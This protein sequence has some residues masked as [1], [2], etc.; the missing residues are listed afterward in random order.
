MY[1]SLAALIAQLPKLNIFDDIYINFF[2]ILHIKS[3]AHQSRVLSDRL[4]CQH[5][6]LC[7]QS[8]KVELNVY[9]QRN[10]EYLLN[11]L[12]VIIS[13]F[14][15]IHRIQEYFLFQQ[16]CVFVSKQGRNRQTQT[17]SW[18]LI[19]FFLSYKLRMYTIF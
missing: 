18:L 10:V 15:P 5:C 14:H 17:R 16:L 6:F 7:D 12:I 19:L 9:F 13:E 3:K 2:G 11:R 8:I 4:T 1:W